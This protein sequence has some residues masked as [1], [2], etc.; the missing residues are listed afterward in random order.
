VLPFSIKRNE[1]E[2]VEM[3]QGDSNLMLKTA[4]GVAGGAMLFSP[5]GMPVVHGLAGLAVAG[6]GI[7]AA[8]NLAFKA[9]GSLTGMENPLNPKET[10]ER[11]QV[12]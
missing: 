11:Q 2:R 4:G 6:L 8:G 3:E 9:I 1:K 10:I 12:H 7:Y 5:L